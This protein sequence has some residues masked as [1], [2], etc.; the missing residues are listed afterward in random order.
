MD[1]RQTYYSKETLDV[2][3]QASK[4]EYD[5]ELEKADK[6]ENKSN[7]VMT[8]I[9]AL[10]AIYIPALPFQSMRKILI[11]HTEL[12]FW[13]LVGALVLLTISVIL[14]IVSFYYLHEVIAWAD[15]QRVNY[16]QFCD[17]QIQSADSSLLFRGLIA[18]YHDVITNND[19][20]NRQ[21]EKQLYFGIRIAVISLIM[22]S[23][24]VGLILVAVA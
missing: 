8:V 2:L 11:A 7:A 12:L 19:A 9:I 3:L 5:K 17:E 6:L 16:D 18:H 10:M 15:I 24:S 21:K 14:L 4:D 23:F 1:G 20:I 13:L 22:L